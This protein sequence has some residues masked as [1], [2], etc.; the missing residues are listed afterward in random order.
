MLKSTL[1]VKYLFTHARKYN[2]VASDVVPQSRFNRHL[3]A[4]LIFSMI[5]WLSVFPIRERGINRFSRWHPFKRSL[6]ILITSSQPDTV[7]NAFRL[8]LKQAWSQSR[9]AFFIFRLPQEFLPVSGLQDCWQGDVPLNLAQPCY[10]GLGWALDSG[11]I[12]LSTCPY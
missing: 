10:I 6:L 7:P 5:I 2:P 8:R 4:V 3:D 11:L 9:H 1:F 12:V